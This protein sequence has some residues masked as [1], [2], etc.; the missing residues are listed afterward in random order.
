MKTALHLT[1]ALALASV[2]ALSQT[3][4]APA[5]QF[6]VAS[7]RAVQPHTAE[8]LQ[9]GIGSPVSSFPANLFTADHLPLSIIISIAFK[10]DSSRITNKPDW[11]DSQPGAQT[12]IAKGP[13]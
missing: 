4:L 3:P 11:L 2:P 6:E 12:R 13:G 7:I 1:L 8:E 10:I 9:R 5:A